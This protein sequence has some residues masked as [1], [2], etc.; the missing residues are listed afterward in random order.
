MNV[1]ESFAIYL[2]CLAVV[3]ILSNAFK[4][5]IVRTDARTRDALDE[6]GRKRT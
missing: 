5:L 1:G 6:W 2:V 3:L 4:L